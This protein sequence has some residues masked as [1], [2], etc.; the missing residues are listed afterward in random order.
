[1]EQ[2]NRGPEGQESQYM[3]REANGVEPMTVAQAD[4]LK[5]LADQMHEP[6]AF[7]QGLSSREASRRID[8]LLEKIRICDLPPHTD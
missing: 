3:V 8:V 6:D 1:M 2:E 5:T 7:E 4:H